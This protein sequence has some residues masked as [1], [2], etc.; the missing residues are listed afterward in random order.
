MRISD[1]SSDVCSSDLK[2]GYRG[3]DV[4][5][6]GANTQ[7]IATLQMLNILEHFDL[8]GAGFQ[9]P[10]SIHLQA[11]AKRLAYED[12]A[13]YYADPHFSNVPVEWLISK[14]YAAERAKLI[15]PDRLLTP[16]HPG[17]APSHGDTTY[18][19][20]ADQ[21][22]MMV[23]MIQSNFRGMGSGLVADGL[24]FMFRSEEHTSEL[25]SLM[26]I[27]SAVFCLKKKKKKHLRPSN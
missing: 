4:Y 25:Q 17:Q 9:S 7:G 24:G 1:W 12:R 10:L 16:V 6:L 21:D 3:T 5:A 2:T 27:S 14:E 22:G 19:S 26:R 15:R 13:R 23:S 8:K 20:C 11:E 18:F